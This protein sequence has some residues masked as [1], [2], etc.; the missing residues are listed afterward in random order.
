MKKEKE[1]KKRKRKKRKKKAAAYQVRMFCNSI[2]QFKIKYALLIQTYASAYG[3]T[4]PRFT[5]MC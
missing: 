2:N 3:L 1:K 4:M 5:A